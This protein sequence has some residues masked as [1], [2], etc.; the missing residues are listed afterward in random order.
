MLIVAQDTN[1]IK[2][3]KKEPGKSFVMK[4]LGQAKQIHGMK[5][6]RD[7]GIKRNVGYL[8]KNIYFIVF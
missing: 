2:T 1:K 4:N 7:K 6:T 8:K 3:S 5:I